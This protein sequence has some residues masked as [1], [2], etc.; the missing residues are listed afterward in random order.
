[1]EIRTGVYSIAE[2]DNGVDSIK[3]DRNLSFEV[4][5][6]FTKSKNAWKVLSSLIDKTIKQEELTVEESI[7][8]LILPDMWMGEKLKM[9]IK[10]LASM[11]IVLMGLANIP[12]ELKAKIAL[13]EMRFLARFFDGEE[14]SEMI[15]MLKTEMRNPKIARILEVYGPGFDVIYDDG[16]TD[17]KIDVA[18][19]LLARGVSEEIISD[20][21]GVSIDEIREIKRK[22]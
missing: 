1:M 6:T 21:T 4:E 7:D 17:G 19:N 16:V 5:T 3:I 22:L 8:L 18:R 20:C 2:P 9:P 14:L 10:A 15:G 13:C 12:D 11:I